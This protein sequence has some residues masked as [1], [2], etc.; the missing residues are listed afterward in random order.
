MPRARN[1]HG[2]GSIRQRKDGTWEARYTLG[3]DPGTGKQIQ[4]SVYGKTEG[5]VA[6]K[7][8]AITHE[9]DQGAYTDPAKMTFGAWLDIWHSEYLG[10]VK[11]STAAQYEY[12]LR[13]HVKPALGAVKLS[14]LTAPMIQK[15]YNS[16]VRSGLSSKSVRN[17]HGVLHKALDQAVALQYIRFNPCDA[18]TLPRV[19]RQEIKPIE[20]SKVREF[21]QAIKGTANE[22]L[23]FVDIFSGLRQAELLGLTWD[24]VDFDKGTITVSKQLRKT[25]IHGGGGT[26][27]FTALKNDKTRMISPAKA[28]FDVLRR[29]QLRQKENQ[30]K[31]G[32]AWENPLNRVFT[33]ALGG[34]LT[35]DTVYGNFKR[36]A[37]RIGIPSTR[38]HD[39]RHTFATL[40][41]Q[42]GDDI[43]TVSANLGHATVAFTLDVYGHVTEQMKKDSADRMQAFI[44]SADA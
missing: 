37:K 25:R 42:N 22:D 34:H 38:F 7:L 5:E 35:S 39:L 14:V 19:E 24:C 41:L 20:G 9:I 18:C 15:L 26:Y 10:G 13:V 32:G 1:A 16:S 3:R 12:Q 31:S 40:S 21:L 23:L 11:A 4:K 33:N 29:V 36:I 8:R 17:M 43:K 27:E 44:N 2:S 30:L 28:V 6:R